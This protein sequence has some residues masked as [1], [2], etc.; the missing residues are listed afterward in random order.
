MGVAFWKRRKDHGVVVVVVVI[1]GVVSLVCARH[2]LGGYGGVHPHFRGGGM[3][4][5]AAAAAAAPKTAAL[6]TRAYAYA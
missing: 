4:A 3:G 6:E 5:A 2:R 1:D